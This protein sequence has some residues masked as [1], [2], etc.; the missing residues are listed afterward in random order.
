[1]AAF[2]GLAAGE[3]VATAAQQQQAHNQESGKHGAGAVQSGN[4]PHSNPF[5]ASPQDR[6]RRPGRSSFSVIEGVMDSLIGAAYHG[7]SGA[8][9]LYSGRLGPGTIGNTHTGQR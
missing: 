3:C 4:R 8:A 5:A 6:R 2:A 7:V 1:M 9:S